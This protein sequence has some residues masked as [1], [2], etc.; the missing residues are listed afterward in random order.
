MSL[1]HAA[2][3]L[4]L[5]AAGQ[6]VAG[7]TAALLAVALGDV[8]DFT[9]LE[10]MAVIL[11]LG[12][13][14]AG[15]LGRLVLGVR[16]GPHILYRQVLERSPPP[17]PEASGERLSRTVVRAV[18]VSAGSAAVFLMAAT[19]L[20][21]FGLVLMGKPRDEVPDHLAPA[22]ALVAAGWLLACAVTARVIA[23]WFARWERQRGRL[24]LCAPLRA[25]TMGPVYFVAPA[26]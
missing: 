11:V 18:G 8:G 17:P 9:P 5:L 16:T 15:A 12:L 24:V 23:S 4:R 13:S 3:E 25:A 20:L 7:V 6:G 1:V 21:A 19:V 14:V 2:T 26:P 10:V 22:A